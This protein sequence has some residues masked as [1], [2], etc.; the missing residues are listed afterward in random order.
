MII[1]VEVR[2]PY[3]K[4]MYYPLCP[5]AK[6]LASM[7]QR[8]TLTERDLEHIKRLGFTVQQIILTPSLG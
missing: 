8:K 7:V 5:Q 3:G 6:L 1:Q 2:T 4:R